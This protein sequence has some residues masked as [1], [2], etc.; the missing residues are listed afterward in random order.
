MYFYNIVHQTIV[1]VIRVDANRLLVKRALTGK[2][3]IKNSQSES[4]LYRKNTRLAGA[5]AQLLII[6]GSEFFFL[7]Q[8]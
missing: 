4:S 3:T 2:K 7:Q 5:T 6:S 1:I 8:P